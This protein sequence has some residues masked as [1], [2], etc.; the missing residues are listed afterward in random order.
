MDKLK[1]R[2]DSLSKK[3]SLLAEVQ[4]LILAE[5]GNDN[6]SFQNK[7]IANLLANKDVLQGFTEFVFDP[8]N[9]V[10]DAIKLEMQE[11]NEMLKDIREEE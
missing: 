4:M 3:I 10:S 5:I 11:I 7:V 9:N 6:P 2:V 1:I 8:A